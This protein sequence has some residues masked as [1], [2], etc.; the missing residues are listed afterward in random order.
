MS[1]QRQFA[2][3]P[4]ITA[5]TVG[6]DLLRRRP[7]STIEV[8]V[9]Q[10]TRNIAVGGVHRNM[11]RHDGSW[12]STMPVT[13]VPETITLTTTI[14]TT[15]YIRLIRINSGSTGND[16]DGTIAVRSPL[17]NDN[18][19]GAIVLTPGAPGAAC[20]SVCGNHLRAT[21]STPLRP[22]P[23]LLDDDVWYSFT[24]TQISHSITV[25]GTGN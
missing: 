14:G 18:C 21:G 11:R 6:I 7:P 15:Y 3:R 10:G 24:A 16:I 4:R 12:M 13:A 1:H 9:A 22:V 5:V 2:Y 20:S 19:G 23:A 17:G 25:D 8:T